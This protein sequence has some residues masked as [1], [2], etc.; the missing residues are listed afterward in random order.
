VSQVT[1]AQEGTEPI[2]DATM[3]MQGI[4]HPRSNMTKLLGIGGIGCLALIVC[5]AGSVIAVYY[6][7]VLSGTH[8]NRNDMPVWS[9]DGNRIA[10]DSDRS[11]NA[12]IYIMNLDGS[13][14]T[15]LTRDPIA[16]LYYIQSP[17]D[18]TA[19]WSP[20]GKQIAFDSGRDNQMMNYVNHDIYIM[21]VNGSNVHRLTND[22][23]DE[24]G[25]RWSPNGKLIAYSRKQYISAQGFI[26][27][28]DWNIFIM[29]ADGSKP[30]QLT[31]DLANELEPAWSPDSAKI[32]F[33]SD[34]N[35]KNADVYVMNA[36]GSNITQLTNDSSNEFGP[37]WSPD[38]TQI[39]FNSDHN[40]NVQLFIM[41]IDG[42]NLIQLTTDTSNSAYGTWSPDG[43]RI[44]FESDR[45]TGQANIYVM[46]ADGSNV[47]QLTGK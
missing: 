2:V 7:G 13:G 8:G 20:D 38:G 47:I 19:A 12:D 5:I 9:P 45:D 26:E 36:D 23:A 30:V 41:N 42:S 22:G 32:A 3:N 1:K 29:N 27:N 25:P 34:S 43:K 15:Q 14:V 17:E 31:N 28:P 37:S 16:T 11:G 46:N 44:I 21:D 39:I 40:G 24:D 18:S 10:F 4:K 33:V 35:G 6:S